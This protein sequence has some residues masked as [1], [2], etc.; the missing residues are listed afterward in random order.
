LWRD[1][2][3]NSPEVCFRVCVDAGDDKEDSRSSSSSC[4][5][6]SESEDDCPLI[7]LDDLRETE[8]KW[9]KKCLSTVNGIPNEFFLF[10][11][12]NL[13]TEEEGEWK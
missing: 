10:L 3:G 6:T 13:D 8:N 1:I 2:K 5:E 9:V 7:L 4:N 11:M 12:T